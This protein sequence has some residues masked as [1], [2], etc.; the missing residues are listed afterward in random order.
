MSGIKKR[1]LNAV[2]RTDGA[3]I[4]A[5]LVGETASTIVPSASK[6]AL[7]SGT[8]ASIAT[9]TLSAGIWILYGN[10]TFVSNA[11]TGN[12][13]GVAGS[14][15][16]TVAGSPG[17]GFETRGL[18]ATVN[19]VQEINGRCMTVVNIS[20]ETTF[21]LNAKGTGTGNLFAYGS[22]RAIRTGTA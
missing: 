14:I 1:W 2:G 6:V 4:S 18:N 16:T 21:N 11:A 3:T 15:G 19:G 10:V 8:Y 7:V 20:A 12:Y 17:T 5:G 9:L 22:I 13:T